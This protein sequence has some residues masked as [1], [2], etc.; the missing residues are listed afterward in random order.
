ML[1]GL[2]CLTAPSGFASDL[3]LLADEPDWRQLDRYQG[4]M[5]HDEFVRLL[6]QVYAP[7]GGWQPYIRVD[8]GAAVIRT[9]NIPLE[10]L[11]TLRFAPANAPAAPA[12][13]VDF[14]LR[15]AIPPVAPPP[16]QP[17]AG[18]KIALDPGHLG[19]RWAR[20]EERWFQI[21]AASPVL[22]GDMNLQVARLA[23]ARLRTLG[24]QATLLRDSDEPSTPL[25][26]YDLLD[27]AARTL[28]KEGIVNPRLYYIGLADPDRQFTLAWVSES[29]FSRAEI[30][31]RGKRVN[32]VLHPDLVV[33]LHF[34]AEAWGD[35]AKPTLVDKNHFHVL[36]NGCYAPDELEKDDVRLEMLIKLLNGS[37]AEELAIADAVAPIL[38]RATGLPP[39][40]YTGF[41]AIRADA[42][43]YIWERNLLANRIDQCPVLYVEP[44]VMN[45]PD[46]FAR[47]Q[48]GD[49]EGERVVNG[50]SRISIF[51]E[52]A[53]GLTN[54]LA[55]YYGHRR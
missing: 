10:D 26:P 29:L 5:A 22:E 48:A 23:A 19:G 28:Q 39:Y 20:Q 47:V 45:S 18:V 42:D 55:G 35:P 17:L 25:R 51:R 6:E 30:R 21:G 2:L 50:V 46:V 43:P 7:H 13:Q 38:A 37:H 41:N 9:T 52:Y 4:T 32:E 49:Y 15:A 12:P 24:A 53:D 16:G 36:I 27:D 40:V 34:N 3:S 33:C 54:G 14:R 11:F 31:A 8:P 1:A 44:Y